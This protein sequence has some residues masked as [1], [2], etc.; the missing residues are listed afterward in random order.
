MA[1]IS[2]RR[3]SLRVILAAATAIVLLAG[4]LLPVLTDANTPLQSMESGTRDFLMRVRG[5]QEP[6]SA[7]V[8]LA[9][10][11]TSLAWVAEQW[12]WP[13]SLLAEIVSKLNEAG[14]RAV[15]LDIFLI[16]ESDEPSGDE[17]LAQAMTEARNAVA[18]MR[19]F[20]DPRQPGA[21]TL[22]RPYP[23]L[24]EALD[25]TGITSLIRDKDAITRSL[26]AYDSFVN[27]TYFNWSFETA[28]LV[29][30]ADAPSSPSPTGLTFNGRS[31]PLQRG[32]LLVNYDGPAGTYPTYSVVELLEGDALEKDPNAFRDKIVLIGATTITLQDVYPTPFSAQALTPGVEIVA[33]AMDMLIAGDYLREAPPWAGLAAIILAAMLALFINRSRRPSLTIT[34]LLASMAAYAVICYAVFVNQRLYLPMVAP[35]AMLFLGVILP[36]VEQAVSEEVEKRRVRNLFTRFISP[37][38]VDQL[39]A[40][41]DI[42]SLNKRANLSILFSDIRGFT[43]LSE[44]LAPEEVVAVLNPYLEVMTGV[45]YKHGGTVDKYEGDAIVAFFG[46]PV[47]YEDHALRAVRAAVDMRK[48][49]VELK[50]RWQKEGHPRPGLEMG[51]GIN[52]GEVFVGMLGSAQRV[53]YTVIG[54]TANLAARI[55]DLTKT[56]VW[57]IL[58]SESTYEAVREEFDAEFADTVIV[59]G[60]TAAVNLYKITGWK[61]TGD[62]V[63]GWK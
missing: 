52:T 58:V 4:Q 50:D 45:I 47:A 34:L 39:I 5:K 21:V 19:I 37:E 60:K 8:I 25:G 16:E 61:K 57:P 63:H 2:T 17:A 42:N 22:E 10:D 32:N 56:Y 26:Q 18:V 54:D 12:P 13:R 43:T 28:R 15:G 29:L 1:K 20:R 51:V 30:G 3:S 62:Q 41:Q 55:Q 7:I 33:N 11:D 9:I 38:M 23:S 53:N 35:Q 46:E 48:A 27:E 40:T 36:T 14:A 6:S 49:L 24:R 31:V 44:K 59:K